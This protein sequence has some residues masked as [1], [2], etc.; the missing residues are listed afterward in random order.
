MKRLFIGLEVIGMVIISIMA[1]TVPENPYEIIPALS[2]MG[3]DRPL[4]L[5][6]I[7]GLGFLYSIALFSIYD[8]IEQKKSSTCEKYLFSKSS[9]NNFM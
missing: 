1:F 5:N 9:N 3:F 4:W 8:N 7:L 2:M 6:T